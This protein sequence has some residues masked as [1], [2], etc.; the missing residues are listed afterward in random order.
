MPHVETVTSEKQ[1][2][3]TLIFL[4]FSLQLSQVRPKFTRD[5]GR[6]KRSFKGAS[7]QVMFILS[8]EYCRV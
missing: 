7:F 1:Q 8:D 4:F 2:Q 6:T 3:K 5:G